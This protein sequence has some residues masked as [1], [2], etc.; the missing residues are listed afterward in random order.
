MKRLAITALV[1]GVM[2]GLAWT[3]AE[4]QGLVHDLRI[5]ADES[6]APVTPA[7]APPGEKRYHL[8]S[9]TS[10]LFIAF[11]CDQVSDQTVQVRVMQPPGA[12]LF[13][14]DRTCATGGTQ[15]VAYSR[16]GEAFPDN[17]YVVNVYVGSDL[18][19]ADSVQFA[20]GGAEIPPSVSEGPT[21]ASLAPSPVAV[22][23]G[24]A[25]DSGDASAAGGPSRWLLAVAGLGILALAAM[26][27]WAGWSAMR[28]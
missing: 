18:Y 5:A 21:P 6:G 4:A 9:G 25:T 2:C 27:L 15:V 23:G 11:A 12:V 8:D 13:Q 14:E 7:D 20:V 1:A 10:E 24:G 19:L 17:E 22:Q 3:Q 16:D 28:T 26:V